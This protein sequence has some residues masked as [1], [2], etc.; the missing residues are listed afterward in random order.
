MTLKKRAKEQNY[1]ADYPPADER[2]LAMKTMARFG[3]AWK[4][5]QAFEIS[6]F[7]LLRKRPNA[8]HGSLQRW[9]LL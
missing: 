7:T 3:E 6:T 5:G 9:D 8:N 1:E 4:E 2:D